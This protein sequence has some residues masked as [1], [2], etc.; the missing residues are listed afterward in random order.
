[1]ISLMKPNHSL[2]TS[3]FEATRFQDTFAKISGDLWR[4]NQENFIMM[5]T[6]ETTIPIRQKCRRQPFG[7]RKSEKKK[8]SMKKAGIIDESN[9]N[10]IKMEPAV[11]VSTNHRKLNDAT[12]KEAFPLPNIQDC[13]DAISGSSCYSSWDL[14]SEFWQVPLN[15]FEDHENTVFLYQF[16]GL[17]FGLTNNQ[18]FSSDWWQMFWEDKNGMIMPFSM[19]A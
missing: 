5:N 11:F 1:M 17:A 12:I 16:T 8:K 18:H 19:T 2:M 14:Q 13:L 4:T 6:D 7:K 15:N 10:K 3:T 9:S